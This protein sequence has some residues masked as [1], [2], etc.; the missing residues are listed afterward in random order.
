MVKVLTLVATF[1]LVQTASPPIL[2]GVAR[3]VTGRPVQGV[4]VTLTT[5]SGSTRVEKTDR[6]GRYAFASLGPGQYSFTAELP[7]FRTERSPIFLDGRKPVQRDIKLT[8]GMLSEELTVRGVPGAAAP[9]STPA[10]PGPVSPPP[11]AGQPGGGDIK[12]PRKVRDVKP[13]YPPELVQNQVAGVVMLSGLVTRQ[14]TVASLRAVRDPDAGLTAAAIAAVSQWR[15]TPTL[16]NCEP[17][18]VEITVTVNFTLGGL[19]F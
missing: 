4:E 3:D 7:G 14:G 16:L 9:T 5:A 13:N 17:V 2:H 1:A 19:F 12:E 6:E 18:D 15:F 8:L 11:C 10:D